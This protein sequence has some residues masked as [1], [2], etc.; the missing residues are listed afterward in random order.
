MSIGSVSID[1]DHAIATVSAEAAPPATDDIPVDTANP[2]LPDQADLTS[3][4]GTLERPGCGSSE[5]GGWQQSLVAIAMTGG[6]VLIFGRVAW[7]VMRNRRN[8]GDVA[9]TP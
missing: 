4:V 9:S 8:D 1:S 6:L 5:R 7:G 2:F 3:C